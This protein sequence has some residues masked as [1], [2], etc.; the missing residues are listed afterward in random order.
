MGVSKMARKAAFKITCKQLLLEEY[1]NRYK[2]LV[3]ETRKIYILKRK[4]DSSRNACDY[5][6]NAMSKLCQPCANHKKVFFKTRSFLFPFTL[7]WLASLTIF[8][9]V[10]I[11]FNHSLFT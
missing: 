2:P 5:N 11:E 9:D 4:K 3:K 10:S 1:I 6:F 8:Q 7:T